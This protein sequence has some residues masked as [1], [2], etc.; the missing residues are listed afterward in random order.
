LAADEKL[1][2]LNTTGKPLSAVADSAAPE[3]MQPGPSRL[4]AAKTKK[5]L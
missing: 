2:D 1:V 5:I 3:F 4:V